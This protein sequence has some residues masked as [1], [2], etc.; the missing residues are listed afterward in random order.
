MALNYDFILAPG[1]QGRPMPPLQAGWQQENRLL[2]RGP[3]WGWS[4]W[5]GDISSCPQSPGPPCCPGGG[6]PQSAP[7]W[8]G[9]SAG[10]RGSGATLR[11]GEMPTGRRQV[12]GAAD[13]TGA[14]GQLAQ[15]RAWGGG[16]SCPL[17]PETL[18]SCPLTGPP[19]TQPLCLLSHGGGAARRLSSCPAGSA[20]LGHLGCASAQGT[21][22]RGQ[23]ETSVPW[24]LV[25]QEEV[26]QRGHD[27]RALEACQVRKQ[28]R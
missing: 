13:R 5:E 15:A 12:R 4:R 23:K 10:P 8:R 17:G 27:V 18:T 2:D 26:G 24:K 3:A 1:L 28:T 20:I 21:E 25:V 16:S 6:S 7:F 9:S 19:P 14:T 11:A 22:C